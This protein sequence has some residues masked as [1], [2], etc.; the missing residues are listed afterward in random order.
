MYNLFLDDERFPKDVTWIKLPDVQ[1]NIVRSYKEFVKTIINLGIPNIVSFDHD[2]ADEHY[3]T[4]NVELCVY[5]SYREK[6]GYHAADWLANRCYLDN[7]KF[8]EYY[9]HTMNP[10]GYENIKSIIECYIKFV[11]NKNES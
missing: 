5:D 8:P 10:V 6:T 11:N 7:R 9:I 4:P 2:L 3:P 1:W